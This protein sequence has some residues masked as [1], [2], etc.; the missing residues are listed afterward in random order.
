M[1][2]SPVGFVLLS[3]LGERTGA[4]ANLMLAGIK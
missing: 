4:V 2:T 1:L 3:F